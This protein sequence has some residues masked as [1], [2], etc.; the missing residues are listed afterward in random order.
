MKRVCL[1][2]CGRIAGGLDAPDSP[3]VLTHAKAVCRHPGF[4][5][6]GCF[7]P[8]PEQA[9]ALASRWGC[10]HVHSEVDAAIESAC[11]LYVI[12]SPSPTHFDLLARLLRAGVGTILCEKPV[13]VNRREFTELGKMLAASRTRLIVSLPRRFDPSHRAL[14]Q[15]I[16]TGGLG[17]LLSF[18]CA[19]NKGLL[20]NGPHV[21]DLV[22]M[23]FGVVPGV[24]PLA[25]YRTDEDLY[26]T[27]RLD[28]PEGA[29]GSLQV[30]SGT[31]FG[32]FDWTAYFERGRVKA[33]NLGYDLDVHLS[34][35]S[36]IYPGFQELVLART[37]D[38]TLDTAFF[39][40]YDAI[41][42]DTFDFAA[43]QD[44]ALRTMDA[45]LGACEGGA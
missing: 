27:F 45:L 24:T 31:Q 1:L 43:L 34:V 21:L 5:L 36:R 9:R 12:A 40:L 16:A 2:G 8:D 41:A 30:I 18:Q 35:P 42:R 29:S 4:R 14:A 19:L 23:M 25:A 11:D 13:V 37:F 33:A 22:D 3:H 26:G 44:R 28:L 6:D 17:R 39:H 20:H 32:L 7:D 15:E 10:A 38:P